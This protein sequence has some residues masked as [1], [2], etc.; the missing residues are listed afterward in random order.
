MDHRLLA[1]AG[2]AHAC[3]ARV[4]MQC[5]WPTE[6]MTMVSWLLCQSHVAYADIVCHCLSVAVCA[7][8]VR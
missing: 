8:Q 7:L 6:M 4:T 5:P 1:D 3:H 2:S